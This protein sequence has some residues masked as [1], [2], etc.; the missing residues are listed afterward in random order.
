MLITIFSTHDGEN[1]MMSFKICKS[2]PQTAKII[3]GRK[4][5]LVRHA[6]CMR[7]WEI[8]TIVCLLNLIGRDHLVNNMETDSRR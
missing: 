7:K 8:Y 2:S 5:R 4:K 1:N 3:K 6:V